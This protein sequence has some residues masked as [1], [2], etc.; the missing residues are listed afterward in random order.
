MEARVE[1]RRD[2]ITVRRRLPPVRLLG[3][4]DDDPFDPTTWSGSSQYLF[5]ALRGHG[6]LHEA[7]SAAPSHLLRSLYKVRNFHPRLA[8]WRFKYQ[9]DVDYRHLMTRTAQR[10]IDARDPRL[11]DVILQ[12]GAWCDLTGRVGKPTV[13]YHDGNLPVLLNSPYPLPPIPPSYV[14]RAL[15]YEANLYHKAHLVLTMSR[16][17]A[18]SFIRDFGISSRKLLPV[19]AGINL[20]RLRE[21]PAKSYDEPRLLFVGIDFQRKGGPTLLKAFELVRRAIPDAT[22]TLVG[23]TLGDPPPGVRVLGRL[24]KATPKGLD[25]LLDEYAAASV[26][27]LP[28]LY[29]PFGIAF[30]EAM[31]HK[32]P[33]VGTNICAIPEIIDHGTTGYLVPPNDSGALAKRL[34]ELLSQPD[35][36]REMGE[37]GYA[38]YHSLYTWDTVATTIVAALEQVV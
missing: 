33:C 30:A 38:K 34:I 14:K 17:L 10:I 20:P 31:A 7:L 21:Q 1:D 9:L 2:H 12:V 13:S 19:G 32:L 23:P 15:Q 24:Q 29:E 16:W 4:I 37:K 27:V 26:F 8:T 25:S 28:S 18:D 11:Y 6:A 3:V 5:T 36:C 22:L 35:Q